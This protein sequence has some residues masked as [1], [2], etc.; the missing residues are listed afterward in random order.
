[1][2]LIYS[3]DTLDSSLI[4]HCNMVLFVLILKV[5]FL[6]FDPQMICRILKYLISGN[7]VV[8]RRIVCKT[9]N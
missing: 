6:F 7:F 5:T 3:V 2:I 9:E 4:V 1:M 8:G